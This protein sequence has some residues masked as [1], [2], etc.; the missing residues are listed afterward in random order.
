MPSRTEKP[1]EEKNN[2]KL[3]PYY[4]L[5]FPEKDAIISSNK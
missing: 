4:L 5:A 3:G 1:E 2:K